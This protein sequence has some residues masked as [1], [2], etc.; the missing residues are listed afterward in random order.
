[1]SSRQRASERVSLYAKS[2]DSLM[3]A[4]VSIVG[5][6]SGSTQPWNLSLQVHSLVAGLSIVVLSNRT[7]LLVF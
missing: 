6:I 3:R 4:S 2:G 7:P 5:G 1:M